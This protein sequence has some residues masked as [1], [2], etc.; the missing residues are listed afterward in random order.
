MANLREQEER[1]GRGRLQES[2]LSNSWEQ[3]SKGL[4][5]NRKFFPK[6]YIFWVLPAAPSRSSVRFRHIFVIPESGTLLCGLGQM[7][8][9]GAMDRWGPPGEEKGLLFRPESILTSA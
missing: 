2:E 6:F 4:R 9:Q 3:G 5:P 1:E 8:R 7:D